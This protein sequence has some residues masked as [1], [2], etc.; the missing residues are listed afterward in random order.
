[1]KLQNRAGAK[2]ERPLGVLHGGPDYFQREIELAQAIF[3]FTAR[4]FVWIA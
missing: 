2:L 1:M 4:N 3:G